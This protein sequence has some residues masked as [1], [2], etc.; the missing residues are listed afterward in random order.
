MITIYTAQGICPK[1]KNGRQAQKQQYDEAGC[2]KGGTLLAKKLA[3]FWTTIPAK[4]L[5]NLQLSIIPSDI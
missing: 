5:M 1:V 3:L 2:E 4:L